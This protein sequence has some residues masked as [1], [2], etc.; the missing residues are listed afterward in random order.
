MY[1]LSCADGYGFV[2][3]AEDVFVLDL[4][5]LPNGGQHPGLV[6]IS[7]DQ[8]LS[9]FDPLRLRSGPTRSLSL[10]HGNVTAMRLWDGNGSGSLVCTAGENGSAS[11]WDLRVPDGKAEAV[12]IAGMLAFGTDLAFG[13]SLHGGESGILTASTMQLALFRYY[14]LLARAHHTRWRWAPS[15][16]INK[17]LY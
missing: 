5:A 2:G 16:L 17:P 11:I 4:A 7:S 6:A 9:L 14:R 1:L 13:G 3:G 10:H 8:T 15:S 12:R